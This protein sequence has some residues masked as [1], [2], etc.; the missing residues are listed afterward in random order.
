MSA[1]SWAVSG[2]KVGEA[3]QASA[4]PPIYTSGVRRCRGRRWRALEGEKFLSL[5]A[6][7]TIKNK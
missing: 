5:L 7:K 2:A 1:Y 6:P 4:S 3:L